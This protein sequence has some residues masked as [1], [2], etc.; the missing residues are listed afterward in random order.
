MVTFGIINFITTVVE[1]SILVTVSLSVGNN[2]V[3]NIKKYTTMI[4]AVFLFN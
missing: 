1:V 3:K 4:T 2:N